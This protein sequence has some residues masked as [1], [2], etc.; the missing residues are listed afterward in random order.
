SLP[1]SLSGQ[2]AA[3]SS[4]SYSLTALSSAGAEVQPL[5]GAHVVTAQEVDSAVGGIPP[6]NKGVDVG[7]TFFFTVGP[8]TENSP[9]YTASSTLTGNPL[10]NLMSETVAFSLSGNSQV[11]MSGFVQQEPVPLPAPIWLMLSGMGG[12][13]ILA[14]QRARSPA[15]I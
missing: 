9:V 11:G 8:M 14:K 6:L 10:Y 12:L 7:D 1:I 3:N 4:V 2:L 5:L 15:V 13:A